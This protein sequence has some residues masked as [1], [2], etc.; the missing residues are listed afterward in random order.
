MNFDQKNET[1]S[2]WVRNGL[3]WK[4]IQGYLPK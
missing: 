2:I 3:I 1:Y 4:T